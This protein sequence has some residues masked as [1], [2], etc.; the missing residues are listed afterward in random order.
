MRC[1][2]GERKEA[3][4]LGGLFFLIVAIGYVIEQVCWWGRGK[5]L[6]LRRFFNLRFTILGR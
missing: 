5:L 2:E 4:V 6:S 1:W 3:A